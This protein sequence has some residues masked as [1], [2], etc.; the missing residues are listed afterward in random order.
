VR[1]GRSSASSA[2]IIAEAEKAALIARATTL[3]EK[4][5]LE[6]QQEQLRQRQEQ[7]DIDAEI[8]AATA[9]IAVL[10]NSDN[11]HPKTLSDG[12]N[13]YY[14]T[15][16]TR[17]GKEVTLNPHVEEY[18]PRN[19]IQQTH[20]ALQSDLHSV[21]QMQTSSV[22]QNSNGTSTSNIYSIM[23]KQNEITA[24]L[25]QCKSK[26]RLL[27]F[28]YNSIKPAHCLK[29]ILMCLMVIL[30]NIELSSELLNME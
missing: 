27:L 2:R 14:D 13:A 22:I 23:Q 28:L 10:N 3:K 17:S 26:M 21:S 16:T 12:M 1:T 6:V 7:M 9:K 11:Q 18:K 30:C 29:E 5:A 25:V 8:A 4:H 19:V 20:S 24:L 15:G